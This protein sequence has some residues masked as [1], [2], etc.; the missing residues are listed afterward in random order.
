MTDRDIPA[1]PILGFAAAMLGLVAICI[2]ASGALLAGRRGAAGSGRAAQAVA[3]SSAGAPPAQ[4]PRL[5]VAPEADLA[6]FQEDKARVLHSYGWV[7]RAAG[8]VRI[9]IQAAIE[10]TAQRGLPVFT[11]PVEPSNEGTP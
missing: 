2:L 10:L 9:P 8:R 4:A 6:R 11:S 7:D 1:R 3:S 5:Q